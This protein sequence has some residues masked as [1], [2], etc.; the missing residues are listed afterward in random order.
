M[1]AASS[2]RNVVKRIGMARGA[3]RVSTT[4]TG[5]GAGNTS[6][7]SGPATG[8]AANSG[9][10]R[11]VTGGGGGPATGGGGGADTGASNCGSGGS[12]SRGAAGTGGGVSGSGGVGASGGV[13]A[14]SGGGAGATGGADGLA[15]LRKEMFELTGGLW[16]RYNQRAEIDRQLFEKIRQLQMDS[17]TSHADSK[18]DLLASTYNMAASAGLFLFGF[19]VGV[20]PGMMTSIVE[21]TDKE[22]QRIL[23]PAGGSPAAAAPG[24]DKN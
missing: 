24:G 11:G 14:N 3:R 7:G 5:T 10:A 16:D 21:A 12:V 1:A 6:G 19:V 13:V 9:G 22:A 23:T 15:E 2:L 4:G 17:G 20:F 8:G 18:G